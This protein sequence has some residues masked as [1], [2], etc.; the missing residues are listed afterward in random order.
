MLQVRRQHAQNLQRI[1]D[2][3][4]CDAA[5]VKGAD[6]IGTAPV[7]AGFL[8]PTNNAIERGGIERNPLRVERGFDMGAD[9]SQ[10][11]CFR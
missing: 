8:G 10:G 7:P 6:Q 2:Q 3:F 11:S 5:G 4:L 9:L 1:R